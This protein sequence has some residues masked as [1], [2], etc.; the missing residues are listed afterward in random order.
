MLFREH[1][2]EEPA[3]LAKGPSDGKSV[4]D[5]KSGKSLSEPIPATKS[6]L[7]DQGLYLFSL[8]AYSPKYNNILL[9]Y[10]HT[11]LVYK[12]LIPTRDRDQ[13]MAV[14]GFG[15]Y[16]FYN[17]EALQQKGNVNQPNYTAVL[18]VDYRIQINKWAFFQPYLQ[19]IIQPN[20]TGAIENATILG[21]ATGAVF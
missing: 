11:G 6:K 13:L 7:S 21:F 17:I 1:S 2:H 16:S 19:D 5:G 4:V 10:F 15:Q 18:E 20:G 3:L 9:F 14:F 8:F 12:G